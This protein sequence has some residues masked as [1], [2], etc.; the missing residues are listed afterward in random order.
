MRAERI[1]WFADRN[2][3]KPELAELLN[4]GLF[5]PLHVKDVNNNQVFIIRTGVHD[6]HKHEQNDVLKVRSPSMKV[7]YC[8]VYDSNEFDAQKKTQIEICFQCGFCFFVL[9]FDVYRS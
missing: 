3:L 4:L 7:K 8:I 5:L 2:P 6:T 9:C 1:E